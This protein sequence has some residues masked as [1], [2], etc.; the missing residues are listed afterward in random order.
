MASVTGP[1]VR[2]GAQRT[3]CGKLEPEKVHR[4]QAQ[5][6]SMGRPERGRHRLFQ[7]AP[8]LDQEI[9]RKAYLGPYLELRRSTGHIRPSWIP[10]MILRPCLLR[11]DSGFH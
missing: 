8:G 4:P 1:L 5:K 3:L 6:L 11:A 7:K 10:S 2:P 9:S